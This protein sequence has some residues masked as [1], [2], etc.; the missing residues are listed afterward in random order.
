MS[1]GNSRTN[2]AALL[3]EYLS[4]LLRANIQVPPLLDEGKPIKPSIGFFMECLPQVNQRAVDGEELSFFLPLV[5][6][7]KGTS[8]TP[9]VA[10]AVNVL[11]AEDS[12]RDFIEAP[13]FF[14]SDGST[15]V[16]EFS[17]GSLGNAITILTESEAARIF[18]R[19]AITGAKG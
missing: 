6:S 8:L 11:L 9:A 19:N 3:S 10:D 16:I 14:Y 5:A 13:T 1:Y 18:V 15:M 4:M 2:A 17:K 12:P 7:G